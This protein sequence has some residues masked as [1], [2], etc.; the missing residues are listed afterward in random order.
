M[1][2]EGKG[3]SDPIARE[4][5]R[6]IQECRAERGMRQ[7]DLAIATGWR[8]DLAAEE[9]APDVLSPSRIG[10]FEQGTRRI[11]YEEAIVL[12]RVFRRPAAWFMA[13]ITYPEAKLLA[14]LTDMLPPPGPSDT[15]EADELHRHRR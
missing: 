3:P 8:K 4:A 13:A 12:Q 11:G 6:R 9:Q 2:V 1:A 15:P 7:E 5:G 10:N 14:A